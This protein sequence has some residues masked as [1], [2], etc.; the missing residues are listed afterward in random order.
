M[1]SLVS[2]EKLAESVLL[3][4]T[5]ESIVMMCLLSL[6]MPGAA[7]SGLTLVVEVLVGRGEASDSPQSSG[8]HLHP[9]PT[10]YLVLWRRDNFR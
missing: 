4:A 1:R 3:E 7:V 10:P 6:S 2:R 9:P 5:V 8:A